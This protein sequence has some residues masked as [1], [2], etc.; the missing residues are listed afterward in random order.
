MQ[1]K[2]F[3]DLIRPIWSLL[4]LGRLMHDQGTLFPVPQLDFSELTFLCWHM[5]Q[6]LVIFFVS[7]LECQSTLF[8][9]SPQ[10][11]F[12]WPIQKFMGLSLCD[13]LGLGVSMIIH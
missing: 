8:Q 1:F 5:G 7:P 4:A 3:F 9:I 11:E 6:H 13:R 10:L 2:G 12:F